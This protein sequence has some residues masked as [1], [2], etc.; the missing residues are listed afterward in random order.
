MKK[1]LQ[2]INALVELG[3]IDKYAIAGGIAQFYYIEP[4]ITYGLDIIIPKLS[5]FYVI[6]IQT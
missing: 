5:D 6:A 3:I 4:S 2:K 1:T